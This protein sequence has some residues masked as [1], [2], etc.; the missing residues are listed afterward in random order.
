MKLVATWVALLACLALTAAS[1]YVP[2]GAWN[3]VA[4]FAISCIKAALIAIFFMELRGAAA[5]IRLAAFVGLVWLA[6]LFGLS[7]TD[8][9]TRSAAP[10]PWDT[11]QGH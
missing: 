7:G 2:M 4:N 9:V 1:S 10:A 11:P 6:L 3:N 5:L 8:Y